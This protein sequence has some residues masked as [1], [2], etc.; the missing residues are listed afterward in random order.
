MYVAATTVVV[1]AEDFMAAQVAF[2]FTNWYLAT[3]QPGCQEL[4]M[5]KS[6]NPNLVIVE[7]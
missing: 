2:T 7:F 5:I 1:L 6:T 3:R 4:D